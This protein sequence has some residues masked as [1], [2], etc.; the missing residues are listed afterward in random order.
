MAYYFPY[1]SLFNFNENILTN[2][3][4]NSQFGIILDRLIVMSKRI[5]ILDDDEEILAIL[6]IILE[7]AGY[8]A[9]AL[10]D[11]EQIFEEIEMFQPDLVLMDIMLSDLDGRIICRELKSRT[12]TQNLPVILISASHNVS[13]SF[14]PLGE[15]NDFIEKPFDINFLVQKIQRQLDACA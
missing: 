14:K 5:L 1:C 15:P 8:E 6:T 11:G 7:E 10:S 13:N 3:I 2:S 4:N 9:K 12:E